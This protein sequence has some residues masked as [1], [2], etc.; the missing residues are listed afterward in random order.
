MLKYLLE[1]ALKDS[2][3]KVILSAQEHAVE[4]YKKQGFTVVSD[5]Y[6]DAGIP[7]FDME[8]LR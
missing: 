4:F 5:V 3:N 8:Y 7:H 2:N 1:I 6:S